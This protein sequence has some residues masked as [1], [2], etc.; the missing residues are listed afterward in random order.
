MRYIPLDRIPVRALPRGY[1]PKVGVAAVEDRQVERS[2]S[3]LS[4]KRGGCIFSVACGSHI[5]FWAAPS[6]AAGKVGVARGSMQ[7]SSTG[8][9][10]CMH[11]WVGQLLAC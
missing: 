9:R 4:P 11:R 8:G 1:G 5:H 2:D 7:A 6:P 10:A 3:A